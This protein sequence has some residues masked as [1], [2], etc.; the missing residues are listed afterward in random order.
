MPFN[1]VSAKTLP[2]RPDVKQTA[3]KRYLLAF[4]IMTNPH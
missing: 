1:S 2:I 4:L 3:A